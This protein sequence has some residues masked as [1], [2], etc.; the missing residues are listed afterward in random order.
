MYYNCNIDSIFDLKIDGISDKF[1]SSIV[2]NEFPFS[3]NNNLIS[4]GQN[5]P[6]YNFNAYFQNKTYANA[7]PFLN[8]TRLNQ[9]VNLTHPLYGILT[10]RISNQSIVQDNY[11]DSCVIQFTFVEYI[12]NDLADL[13]FSLASASNEAIAQNIN[14]VQNTFSP[15]S[16]PKSVLQKA[17]SFSQTLSSQIANVT[18]TIRN[19]IAQI[20]AVIAVLESYVAL[21]SDVIDAVVNTITYIATLPGKIISVVS[22][23]ISKIA[24]AVKAIAG[25]PSLF[26]STI[27]SECDILKASVSGIVTDKPTLDSINNAIDICASNIICENINKFLDDDNTNY[28][29]KENILK[30]KQFDIM[31]NLISNQVEID[32]I[33]NKELEKILFLQ[34]KQ[35]ERDN[36]LNSEMTT[37]NNFLLANIKKYIDSIKLERSKSFEVTID[38]E[39]PLYAIMR[40][41]DI[42][43]YLYSKILSIN[44]IENPSFVIGKINLIK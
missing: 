34:S 12:I 24:S 19:I 37:N 13:N 36:F 31:G 21:I 11:K 38:S 15:S 2:K 41:Y 18:S 30:Q 9:V 25:I 6:E 4:T 32:I 26:I 35:F 1:S 5:A 23:V 16:L 29:Q 14:A 10:G 27:K 7:I 8:Y 42:P 40:K 39:L 17:V 22:K 44:N 33:D 28:K 3:N 20:D 43:E